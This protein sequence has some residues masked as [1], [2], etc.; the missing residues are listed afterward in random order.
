VGAPGAARHRCGGVRSHSRTHAAFR[1][2]LE[3]TPATPDLKERQRMGKMRGSVTYTLST[4]SYRQRA[5]RYLA[6]AY[7]TLAD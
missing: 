3:A 4:R 1:S 5:S 2:V 6:G 7:T